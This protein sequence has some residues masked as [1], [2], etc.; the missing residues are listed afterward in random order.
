MNAAAKTISHGGWFKGHVS[1]D[2]LTK[3]MLLSIVLLVSV[4]LSALAIVYVKNVERFY[5]SELQL[6]SQQETQLQ[7]EWG[8]L[9]LEKSA[10]LAPSQI[11]AIAQRHLN[12]YV[13]NSKNTIM[14]KK[15]YAVFIR[16]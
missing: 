6:N 10:L 12:M 13:P 16:Q 9:I 8:K 4:L 15:D 7:L 11:Q 2:L 3:E 1:Q 14:I 5:F